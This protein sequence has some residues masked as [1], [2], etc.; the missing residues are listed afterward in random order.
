M[1]A[2]QAC[3]GCAVPGH[4]L[5]SAWPPALGTGLFSATSATPLPSIGLV[6]SSVETSSAIF[7]SMIYDFTRVVEHCKKGEG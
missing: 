5:P 6:I 7:P 4:T 2:R 1:R 3:G